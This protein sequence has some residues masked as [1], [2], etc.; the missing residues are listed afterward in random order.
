MATSKNTFIPKS[1]HT[2]TALVN[3]ARHLRDRSPRVLTITEAVQEAG[4]VLG[5]RG[6]SDLYGLLRAAQVT[7]E[8]QEPSA[9]VSGLSDKGAVAF[10]A[11]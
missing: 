1:L 2:I 11:N 7:L 6:K 8:K 5:L 4:L 9:P 10:M 3:V